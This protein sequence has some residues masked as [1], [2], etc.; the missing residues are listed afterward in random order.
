LIP[1]WS[2]QDVL[3][4]KLDH[5]KSTIILD[6]INVYRTWPKGIWGIWKRFRHVLRSMVRHAVFD[7]LMTFFVMVNT[8]TLCLD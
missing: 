7:S 1:I 3:P 4:D 5:E 2:G 6:L 8:V